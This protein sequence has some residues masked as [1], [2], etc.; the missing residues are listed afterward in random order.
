M[1]VLSNDAVKP[2]MFFG[3]ANSI[4]ANPIIIV[5]CLYLIGQE[6]GASVW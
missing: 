2:V 6:I 5:L 1:N 3:L 4:W